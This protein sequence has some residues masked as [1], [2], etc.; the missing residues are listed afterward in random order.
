MKACKKK[1][2]LETKLAQEMKLH[3]SYVIMYMLQNDIVVI[4]VIK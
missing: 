3:V 2:E 1:T 4:I